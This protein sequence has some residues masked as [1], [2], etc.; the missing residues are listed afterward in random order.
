MEY[1]KVRNKIKANRHRRNLKKKLVDYKG[2]KCEICGYDKCMRAMQFHHKDPSQKD[3]GIGQ[4]NISDIEKLKKEIDKCQ[5]LC[6]N[7]H[8]EVHEIESLERD[9]KLE[10]EL[11]IPRRDGKRK[12]TSCD[13]RFVFMGDRKCN[14]CRDRIKNSASK[15][16]IKK[17]KRPRYKIVWPE[18]LSELVWEKPLIHLAKELEVS[19]NAIRKRCI[20]LNIKLP[21]RGFWLK[22]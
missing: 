11:K 5:L 1:S 13:N 22:G 18:N 9:R 20:K 10:D 16:K 6:S 12:C 4:R 2:G 14:E 15:T 17:E 8:S 21:P 3:F 19:D 7:C